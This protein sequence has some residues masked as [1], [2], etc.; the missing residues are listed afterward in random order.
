MKGMDIGLKNSSPFAR[1]K[2]ARNRGFSQPMMNKLSTL[3]KEISSVD[4][5]ISI[6][7]SKF[8]QKN[9][10]KPTEAELMNNAKVAVLVDRR[11]ELKNRYIQLVEQN[12]MISS[13]MKQFNRVDPVK[14]AQI[15]FSGIQF[16][17]P[18]RKGREYKNPLSVPAKSPQLRIR[19]EPQK[20]GTLWDPTYTIKDVSVHPKIRRYYSR[21]SGGAY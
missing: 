13:D 7:S 8:I 14:Q 18:M 20:Q 5:T 4:R 6:E 12:T 17:N 15:S 3:R 1:T 16:Q 10:R 21:I 9:K 19:Q 2:P 11:N